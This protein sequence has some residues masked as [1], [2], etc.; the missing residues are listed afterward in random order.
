MRRK[1]NPLLDIAAI[2]AWARQHQIPHAGSD[3]FDFVLRTIAPTICPKATNYGAKGDHVIVNWP[4]WTR[5]DWHPR[6]LAALHVFDRGGELYEP[7]KIGRPGPRV[8]RPSAYMLNDCPIV[9][10]DPVLERLLALA[11]LYRL[12]SRIMSPRPE[13]VPLEELVQESRRTPRAFDTGRHVA[14]T[15][16]WLAEHHP[17]DRLR[18]PDGCGTLSGGG[19]RSPLRCGAGVGR[20]VTMG[21]IERPRG[22][23]RATFGERNHRI[24]SFVALMRSDRALGLKRWQAVELVVQIANA[25]PGTYPL[26]FESVENILDHAH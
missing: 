25:F 2:R 7:G 16:R 18:E 15:Y 21:D 11:T 12:P 22:T 6:T 9:L 13:R 3:R 24:R 1:A 26:S 19:P 10:D 20:P 23:R 5:D 17:K 4:G 8:A 14:A